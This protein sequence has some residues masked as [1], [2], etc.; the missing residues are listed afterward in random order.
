MTVKGASRGL[1]QRINNNISMSVEGG[2]NG[3]ALH[4]A[5]LA[6]KVGVEIES[7]INTMIASQLRSAIRPGGLLNQ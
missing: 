6:R 5:E 4:E 1:S 7:K 3:N 2:S